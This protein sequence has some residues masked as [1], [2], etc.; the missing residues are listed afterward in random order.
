MLKEIFTNVK[1]LFC[2]TAFLLTFH[3]A[4]GQ[5]DIVSNATSIPITISSSMK[6]VIFDGKWTFTS[7]WKESSLAGFAVGTIRVAHFENF[8]YV[9]IDA[10]SL[11][12]FEKN[13]DRAM[14]CF[15][16]KDDKSL[17]PNSDDYCFTT[18]LGSSTAITLQGGSDLTFNSNFKKI[19][20]PEGLIA[21]GGISDDNDRY[22]PIRHQSY[23]FKIP[24]DLIGRSDK[25]GFYVSVFDTYSNKIYSWPDMQ[26]DSPLKIPSPKTWGML[27]SPDESLPEF[28]YPFIALIVS[29]SFLLYLAKFNKKITWLH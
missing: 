14:V 5:M 28:P 10:T 6:N 25:Y 23:E 19:L 3:L 17:I 27:W 29:L 4:Y 8:V 2:I 9:M 18:T 15:D 1:T 20:S 22:T 11:T 21:V 13:S 16:T 7:E 12:K 26:Q 24:T